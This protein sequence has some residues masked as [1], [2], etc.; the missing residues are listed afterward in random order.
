MTINLQSICLGAVLA[1]SCLLPVGCGNKLGSAPTGGHDIQVAVVKDGKPVQF[2]EVTLVPVG[3][4]GTL[5]FL[6]QADGTGTCQI[7]NV[8]EGEYEVRVSRMA[9][10]GPDAAFA[11]YGEGSALRITVSGTQPEYKVEL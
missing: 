9:A 6:G 1:M 11:S 5:S 3:R 2:A 10:G 8:P 4:D 7:P